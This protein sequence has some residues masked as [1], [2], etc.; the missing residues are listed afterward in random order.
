MPSDSERNGTWQVPLRVQS[1]T[2]DF[3]REGTALGKCRSACKVKL[4]IL[5]VKERHLASAASGIKQVA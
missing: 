1:E 3:D 4:E 2:R 5:I